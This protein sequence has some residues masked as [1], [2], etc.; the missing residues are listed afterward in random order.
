MM[1]WVDHLILGY[2]DPVRQI[3]LEGQIVKVQKK[4]L[5]SQCNA[6]SS[7]TVPC[8]KDIIQN[9]VF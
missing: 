9:E 7:Q 1:T 8:A 4:N 6:V 5:K 2:L 3:I